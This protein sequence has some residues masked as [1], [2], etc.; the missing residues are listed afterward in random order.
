MIVTVGYSTGNL[1]MK[2]FAPV[3]SQ[4][5]ILILLKESQQGHKLN[6]PFIPNLGLPD[7][8]AVM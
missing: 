3:L 8:L 6:G 5:R 2:T 7:K 1:L 4:F